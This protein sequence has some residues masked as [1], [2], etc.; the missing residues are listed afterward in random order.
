MIKILNKKKKKCSKN[1][2]K[3]ITGEE[4]QDELISV[5]NSPELKRDSGKDAIDNSWDSVLTQSREQAQTLHDGLLMD[6]VLGPDSNTEEPSA[7]PIVLV[8]RRNEEADCKLKKLD[9]H[10]I[11]RLG[12]MKQG[13]HEYNSETLESDRG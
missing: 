7:S 11:E 10:M 5:Q 8:H 13:K 4:N 3:A 6:K 1:K 9:D 2:G 12:V